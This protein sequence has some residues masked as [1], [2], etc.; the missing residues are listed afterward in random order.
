[1]DGYLDT[2][3]TRHLTRWMDGWVDGWIGREIKRNTPKRENPK[4][5]V[6]M[7]TKM[8]PYAA[9]GGASKFA[10]LST[11]GKKRSKNILTGA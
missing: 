11:K 4:T 2:W 1:M 9:S 3:S 10:F 5:C 8:I 7:L 6:S